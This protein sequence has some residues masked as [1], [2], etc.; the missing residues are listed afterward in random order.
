[1]K[2]LKEGISIKGCRFRYG[3][4]TET[5]FREKI[6]SIKHSVNG[7]Q[8]N[9]GL[10]A[11]TQGRAEDIARELKDNKAANRKNAGKGKKKLPETYASMQEIHED[12]KREQAAARKDQEA[13]IPFEDFFKQFIQDREDED[14]PHHEIVKSNSR[15]KKWIHSVIGEKPPQKVS[16]FDLKRV[17]KRMTKAGSA[18]ETIRKIIA[19]IG[20]VYNHHRTYHNYQHMNPVNKKAILPPQIRKHV[21]KRERYLTTT[22][23]AA[24]LDALPD[25]V[26]TMALLSLHM[27]FRAGELF[28]LKWADI[29][30]EEKR[31]SI[32]DTKNGKPRSLSMTKA[33]R[34]ALSKME[35]GKKNQHVF[36][37]P[38]SKKPLKE[39]PVV[40]KR[41]VDSLGLNDHIED[42]RQRVV[43]HSLRHTCA[44]WL[45]KAGVDLYT[46]KEVL[47][48]S[49]ITVTERYVHEGAKFTEAA[50]V[51]DK[52]SMEKPQKEKIVAIG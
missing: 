10:G 26:A 37:S 27:G 48:H 4:I 35:Q 20:Q 5:G 30:L 32:R 9:E 44:S 21:N 52:V 36:I 15:Y 46:V 25:P 38:I 41:T 14:R 18:P 16:L 31:I 42:R 6:W 11:I 13:N 2:K 28:S 29:N 3:K 7:K 49:S 19:L 47:G 50:S 33:V 1:M 43:F 17:V 22:E 8:I 45:I 23:A 24:L 51:M 12:E 39:A 34:S 40:F